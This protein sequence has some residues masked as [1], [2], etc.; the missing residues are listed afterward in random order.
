H[1]PVGS[2]N[3]YSAG[4]PLKFGSGREQFGT[5]FT[6]KLMDRQTLQYFLKKVPVIGTEGTRLLR[7]KRGQWRPRR[8]MPRRLHDRPRK[9][10]AWS[11]NQR[12]YRIR[13]P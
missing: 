8:R 7:E 11:G 2:A 3:R 4:L 9:A 6:G 13:L 10:S 5:P 12:Y 1:A